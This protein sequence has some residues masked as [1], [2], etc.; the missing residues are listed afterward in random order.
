MT[1]LWSLPVSCHSSCLLPEPGATPSI[2]ALASVHY[3]QVINFHPSSLNSLFVLTYPLFTFFLTMSFSSSLPLTIAGSQLQSQPHLV[4]NEL[5]SWS[6]LSF[7]LPCTA[8][9][10]WS[11]HPCPNSSAHFSSSLHQNQNFLSTML[12]HICTA[13]RGDHKES[14]HSTWMP[15]GDAQ[16]STQ[17]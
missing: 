4:R 14:K 16:G 1:F 13:R 6:S 12:P 7:L 5:A 17:P 10:S 11:P 3:F 2:Q 8:L 9:K 15:W